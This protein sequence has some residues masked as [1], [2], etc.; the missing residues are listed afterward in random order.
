MPRPTRGAFERTRQ[1]LLESRRREDRLLES[2][3]ETKTLLREV[4][5]RVKNNLQV[6]VSLLTMQAEAA[7]DRAVE[8]ALL[9]ATS[10]VSA[11]ALIHAMLSESESL[12]EVDLGT[13]LRTLVSNVQRIIGDATTTVTQAVNLEGVALPLHLATPCGL[14]VN[15][16]LT[17]ASRHAFAGATHPRIEVRA[18]A[19]DAVATIVV[20]DN[21]QGMPPHAP[22]SAGGIGLR[23]IHTLAAK[24]LHGML[25]V[26]RID[27]TTCTLRFPYG[28]DHGPRQTDD[29]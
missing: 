14:I 2:L 7:K 18:H 8:R 24:Q 9:E 12:A 23:L 21:G 20:Q 5:H 26:S 3:R 29:R 28:G 6:V 17:N 22:A 27:G 16:L 19:K 1:E 4:H 11:I 13:F 10:R 25:T 15:E